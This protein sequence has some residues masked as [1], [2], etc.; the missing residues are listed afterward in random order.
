MKLGGEFA[1]VRI[2]D[3]M[4]RKFHSK[5]RTGSLKIA[6]RSNQEDVSRFMKR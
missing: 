2:R 6:E 5:D 3:E 4:E 1:M